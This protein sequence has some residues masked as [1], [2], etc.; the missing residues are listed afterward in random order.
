MSE[1]TVAPVT[2]V[3]ASEKSSDDSSKIR[4][5]LSILRKYVPVD[6]VAGGLSGWTTEEED[7]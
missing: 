3:T 7:T 4:T 1:A 2:G 5:F 6:G